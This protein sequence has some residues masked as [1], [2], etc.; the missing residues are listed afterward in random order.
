MRLLLLLSG[1]LLAGIDPRVTIRVNPRV[2]MAGAAA[3]VTCKVPRDARNRGLTVGIADYRSSWVQIDGEAGPATSQILFERI[4]CGVGDAY[5][6]LID[7]QGTH[8]GARQPLEIA[9]CEP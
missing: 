6:D 3:W 4:P 9:G 2:I 5:C 1:I 8:A 7:N